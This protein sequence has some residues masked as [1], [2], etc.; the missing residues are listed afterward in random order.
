MER[1]KKKLNID[2]CI[3][4]GDARRVKKGLTPIK[5][6]HTLSKKLEIDRGESANAIYSKLYR[7]EKDG[8]YTENESFI[9]DIC[10]ILLVTKEELVKEF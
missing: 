8:F 4:I 7:Y 2:T 6:I 1:I 9:N 5:N 3:I 10:V